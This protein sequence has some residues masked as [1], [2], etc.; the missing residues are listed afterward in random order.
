M[1]Q[2][3]ITQHNLVE[4]LR[5]SFPEIEVRLREEELR[6]SNGKPGNYIVF[7]IVFDPLLKRELARGEVTEFLQRLAVFMERVCTSSDSEAINVIWIEIFEWLIH[8]PVHLKLL[9]PIL[10]SATKAK[11]EDAAVRWGRIGDLPISGLPGALRSILR[12][13]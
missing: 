1:A 7:G 3:S 11:I 9:W 8:E 12:R 6:A 2:E 5:R 10:G 13:H 4:Q